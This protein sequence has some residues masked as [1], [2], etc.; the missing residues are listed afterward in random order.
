MAGAAERGLVW[1]RRWRGALSGALAAKTGAV[2]RIL[3]DGP[4]VLY[5]IIAEL[6]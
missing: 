4:E 1:F 3:R 2:V 5:G 6:S